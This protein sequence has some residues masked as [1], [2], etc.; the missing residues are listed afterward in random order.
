MPIAMTQ[1]PADCYVV[2]LY[3]ATNPLHY[4]PRVCRKLAQ[5]RFSLPVGSRPALQQRLPER[6]WHEPICQEDIAGLPRDAA[7]SRIDVEHAACNGCAAPVERA[8]DCRHAVDR[9]NR[10]SARW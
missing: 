1:A 8:A 2:P 10:L 6:T 3:G 4:R 5:C 7:V 9:R